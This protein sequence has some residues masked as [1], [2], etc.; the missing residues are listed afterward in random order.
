MTRTLPLKSGGSARPHLA[1]LKSKPT[2]I[3]CRP[4][5]A[6][7]HGRNDCFWPMLL[8]KSFSTAD[9]NFPRPLMRFSDNYVRTSSP[10]EKLTGDFD[11]GL[12]AIFNRR[13]WFSCASFEKIAT[14]HFRTFSTASVNF[15]RF[16]RLGLS[17]HVRFA[18][19]ANLSV[20][21]RA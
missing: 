14:G 19:K 9:Q 16:S 21:S 5:G 4:E 15:D 12:G 1:A 7:R 13:G 17:A 10:S 6:D 18:P 8:K 20:Q 3:S 11:N 2:A